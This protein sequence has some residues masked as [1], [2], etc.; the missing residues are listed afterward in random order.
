LQEAT[1]VKVNSINEQVLLAWT[2][3]LKTGYDARIG[4]SKKDIYLFVNYDTPVFY[5]LYLSKG[6]QKY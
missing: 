4:Y 2:A 6:G 5:K 1:S 3:L